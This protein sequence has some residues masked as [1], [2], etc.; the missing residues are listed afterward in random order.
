MKNIMRKNLF[1][2]AMVSFVLILLTTFLFNH[3][4]LKLNDVKKAEA[5]FIYD[6]VNV[7]Y[8]LNTDDLNLI[9]NIFNN[10]VSY[11]DNLSCGFSSNIAI[12]FNDSCTLCFACDTCPVVYWKEENRYIDITESEKACLY[13]FLNKHGFFF[14]CI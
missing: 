2:L 4:N 6:G 13:N 11:R 1:I 10:K 5:I 14:P 3:K 9:L 12:K 8:I 7:S